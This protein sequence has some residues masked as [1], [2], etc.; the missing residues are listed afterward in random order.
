MFYNFIT[1]TRHPRVSTAIIDYLFSIFINKLVKLGE[2]I[3]WTR[4][5]YEEICESIYELRQTLS[6]Q[7]FPPRVICTVQF[8]LTFFPIDCQVIMSFS[9][10][11][12]CDPTILRDLAKPPRPGNTERRERR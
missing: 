1:T 4:F 3:Q 6:A 8:E 2:T 12:R 7:P 11:S 9:S 5:T 10:F